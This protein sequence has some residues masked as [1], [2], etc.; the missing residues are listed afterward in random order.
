MAGTSVPLLEVAGL[1]RELQQPQ[2]LEQM[3]E[4]VVDRAALVCKTKHASLRLLDAAGSRL[5]LGW[6]A[7]APLHEDGAYEFRLGEG[8]VGWVVQS[9]QVLRSGNVQSD[10]RF[11]VRIDAREPWSSFLGVPLRQ[12]GAVFGALSVAH[13]LVD[14]FTEEHEHWMVLIA[15][16]AGPALAHARSD[17]LAR[18][19]PATGGLS[20]RGLEAALPPTRR[21]RAGA[22]G[23]VHSVCL[24]DI[25]GFAGLNR[26]RGTAM[27]DLVLRTVSQALAGW[28]RLG[29]GIV[30]YGADA[31]LIS[32]P[33][34]GVQAALRIADRTRRAIAELEMGGTQG[35]LRVTVS[36]G[37]AQARTGEARDGLLR[38]AE[39]ALAAAR[40]RGGNCVQLTL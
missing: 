14:A 19:D 7:G 13:P 24:L 8:L 25:D 23:D 26:E 32:L 9:G 29:D 39:D 20:A 4:R 18:L 40:D 35:A 16:L 5:L 22:D 11:L 31:F 27:G 34:V 30:R 36:V 17:R 6:R 1:A 33:G 15:A 28:L 2:T 37:V 12:D 10:P 3:L 21:V 38:R